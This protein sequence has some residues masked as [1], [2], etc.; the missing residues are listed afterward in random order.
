M[1]KKKIEAHK[2]NLK[3]DYNLIQSWALNAKKQ[4]VQR[5]WIRNKAGKAYIR[6]DENFADCDFDFEWTKK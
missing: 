3:D 2:A 1:V 5:D 6:I 4:Q